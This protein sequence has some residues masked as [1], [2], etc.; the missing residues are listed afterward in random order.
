MFADERRDDEK[1]FIDG[2]TLSEN[3]ALKEIFL[4]MNITS[5]STSKNY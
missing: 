1:Y 3:L 2:L 4:Q 5:T